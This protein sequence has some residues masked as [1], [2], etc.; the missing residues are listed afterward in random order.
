MKPKQK[1]AKSQASGASGDKKSDE[2]K[3]GQADA[4]EKAKVGARAEGG[5]T[6]KE[7]GGGKESGADKQAGN[8]QKKPGQ[9]KVP[10][11]QEI[12]D[13]QL[14]IAVESR[15]VEKLLGKLKGTTDLAK[16][17]MAAASKTAEDA[18]SALSRGNTN[19]A[20]ALAKLARQQFRELTEQVR[21]LL[22]KEQAERIAAAQRMATELAREQQDFVDRLANK[23]EEG[24]GGDESPK[25][26]KEPTPGTGKKESEKKE[27]GKKGAGKKEKDMPGLDEEAAKIAERAKTL[28]DVLGAASKADSPEDQASA[29]KIQ[30]LMGTLKLPELTE[31]LEQLPGQVRDGKLQ[32]AK[33]AAGDG[34]ERME[35]AAEALAALH[36]NIVA[37]KMDELAKVEEKLTTLE[38]D[39]ERLDTPTRITAW[40]MDANALL[41]E[42][43]KLGI[44]KE[45]RDELL[46]QMQKAGWGPELKKNGWTWGRTEGGYYV[47]PGG[48][49]VLLSRL[50]SS[51]HGRMQELMLV[52]LASS[53]DE[54]IPPQYQELVD[55]FHRI[56]ATEGKGPPK[57][58]PQAKKE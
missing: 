46:K 18:G 37:P 25:K 45:L 51:V 16:E 40:H 49:R 50:L 54:P 7:V 47:A 34:Q 2:K 52:D 9:G 58:M 12:E 43:A 28:A 57:R 26:K 5:E 22:A 4:K 21:A 38:E 14:D 42:L 55:R 20:Q 33:V 11:R 53:R 36:R 19:E 17:R 41:E 3:P 15:E 24:G 6:G 27:V 39:L 31:R 32:D 29:K 48:Y 30:E 23:S 44:S 56:L 8:G 1:D 13:L 35:A 10:S